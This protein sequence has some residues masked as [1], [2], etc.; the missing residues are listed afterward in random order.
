MNETKEQ[1]GNGLIEIGDWG[2]CFSSDDYLSQ[3]LKLKLIDIVNGKRLEYS[4]YEYGDGICVLSYSVYSISYHFMCYLEG[5]TLFF[6]TKTDVNNP[7]I[8]ELHFQISKKA[9]EKISS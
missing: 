6:T 2:D 4:F 9:R 8:S 5:K 1:F 7:V 3:F